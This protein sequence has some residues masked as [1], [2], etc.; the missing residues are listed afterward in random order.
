MK[1]YQNR[2]FCNFKDCSRFE[3]CPWDRALTEEHQ[4]E[5]VKWW[6]SGEVPVSFFTKEPECLSL[7][8]ALPNH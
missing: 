2:T 1:T 8:E 5:A 7:I 4:F 6:G 3:I